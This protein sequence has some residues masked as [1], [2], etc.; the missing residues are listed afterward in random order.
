MVVTDP[1]RPIETHDSLSQCR[2]RCTVAGRGEQRVTPPQL[3]GP[4]HVTAARKLDNRLPQV[5][6]SIRPLPAHQSGTDEHKLA[7]PLGMIKGK[8]QGDTAS[9]R[10]TDQVHR[11]DAGCV[12]NCEQVIGMHKRLAA[13]RD[14]ASKSSQV[15]AQGLLG[16][17]K[18]RPHR[19]PGVQ[20]G[21]KTMQKYGARRCSALAGMKLH[22]CGSN[23]EIAFHICALPLHPTW[24]PVYACNKLPTGKSNYASTA[25]S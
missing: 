7:D 5:L 22:V 14:G 24:T 8:V 12:K 15:I 13:A 10:D 4:A 19:V 2:T 11:F 3:A 18:L 23:S 17:F 1:L 20:V 9:H 16:F 25:N 6:P 21:G